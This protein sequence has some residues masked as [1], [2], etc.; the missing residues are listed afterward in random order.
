MRLLIPTIRGVSFRIHRG[1]QPDRN[2]DNCHNYLGSVA[3]EHARAE[4]RPMLEDMSELGPPCSSGL[5]II[6]HLPTSA[7]I[8][9]LKRPL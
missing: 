8:Y 5:G 6:E 1:G 4:R 7:P 3:H 9:Y 2:L